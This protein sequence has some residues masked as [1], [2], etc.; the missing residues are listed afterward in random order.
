MRSGLKIGTT[1]YGEV[2]AQVGTRDYRQRAVRECAILIRQLR[3]HAEA[4][5]V[6]LLDRQVDLR[7]NISSHDAGDGAVV[8]YEVFAYF[9]DS[10]EQA[11]EAA[12]WLECSIPESWDEIARDEFLDHEDRDF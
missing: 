12:Y 1:P 6:N 11:V 5:G 9:D 4:S 7:M 8:Y 3:R 10:D 2:C